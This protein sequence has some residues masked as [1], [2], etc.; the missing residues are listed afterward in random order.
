MYDLSDNAPRIAIIRKASRLLTWGDDVLEGFRQAGANTLM[1][2]LRN[3]AITER[4]EQLRSGKRHFSSQSGMLRIATSLRKFD[5]HLVLI[6][7]FAGIPDSA[8]KQ[9][10]GA[11]RPGV[12]VVGWLC[13]R[14]EHLPHGNSPSLDGVYYFDSICRKPLLKAYAGTD[15]RISYLP[16]AACPKRYKSK[17]IILATRKPRAVFA[18]NCTPERM[19]VF[20]EF[21]ALKGEID[22]FGPNSKNTRSRGGQLSP[23]RIAI[24]YQEY[25]VSFNLLQPGNTTQ[26]LNL[27]AFE[28]PCAGGLAIYPDVP[29]LAKCFNPGIEMVSYGSISELKDTLD[30]LLRNPDRIDAITRAGHARALSEHTFFHRAKHI[31]NEYLPILP[32]LS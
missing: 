12:P 22:L 24:L 3:E 28:I 21:R 11:V 19:A 16:L 14:I 8:D 31:L 25:M 5:P 2:E 23:D 32:I 10:R 29:D 6:L 1:I 13:D 27:R 26:G 15:A 17:P 9:I 7:N 30:L 20:D 18:G 4:W